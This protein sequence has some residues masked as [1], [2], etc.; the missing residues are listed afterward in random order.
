[1][2]EF[3]PIITIAMVVASAAVVYALGAYGIS[4]ARH[5][6]KV[7]DALRK[8]VYTEIANKEAT[9]NAEREVL[10][11]SI[12]GTTRYDG[13]VSRFA[14]FG[15]KIDQ[16]QQVLTYQHSEGKEVP[17]EVIQSAELC[18]EM[19]QI[20]GNVGRIINGKEKLGT[21]QTLY[22]IMREVSK[23]NVSVMCVVD[24]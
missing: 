1:M 12:P 19:G 18:Y 8:A 2:S 22:F 23:D 15:L 4:R 11:L 10:E 3:E 20:R 5:K 21:N 9:D 13:D 14:A 17:P 6:A 16:I 24:S 7:Q